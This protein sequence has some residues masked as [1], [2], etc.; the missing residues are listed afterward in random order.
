[1]YLRAAFTLS[2]IVAFASV[3]LHAQM[4]MDPV[5]G[6][7][8]KASDTALDKLSKPGAFSAD[9]A[10][11]IGLPGAGKNLGGLMKYADQ[12]GVTN[13]LSGSLNRAAEKA[14][15]AAKPIFTAA[16]DKMNVKD[17]VAI[18]TGGDTGATDYLRK[19]AGDQINAQLL[20][21]IRTALEASG[22]LKQTSQ[23][24]AVGMNE[25]SV[26]D[27]VT[28]KAA[29]GIFTYMGREES[30]LRKD[31]MSAGKNLLKGLKF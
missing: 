23:L 19:S 16:I 3:P 7:L 27:Y 21:L 9:D 15:G 1:M 8:A 30:Q 5:K 11:R 26:T 6:V 24:S 18:G 31:P 4:S 28:Q 12:A 10:I 2:I 22:V 13:D 25:G 14:A 29:D 17:A 20:P